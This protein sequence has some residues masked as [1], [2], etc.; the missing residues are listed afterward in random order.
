MSNL[1]KSKMEDEAL[2]DKFLS[3]DEE[4]FTMLVKKY[5]GQVI[6]IVYSLTGTT[7]SAD[8]IAQEVFIKVYNKLASFNRKARFFTWLYRISVNTA[9]NYLKREKRY[10]SAER[11][12]QAQAF[13][14]SAWENLASQERQ[15]FIRQALAR[16]PFNFRSAIVLRE[17]EGLSYKDI[18]GIMRCR[19]GTVESRLFRAR[20]M[21]KEILSP[22]LRE[23]EKDEM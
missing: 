6:N 21:L 15:R 11:I 9:Y 1:W 7:A 4:G 17:I 12:E 3:G 10:A 8:D 14:Q 2:I 19:I 23:G 13:N 5:Q 22:V 16:L 18:A 20:Q